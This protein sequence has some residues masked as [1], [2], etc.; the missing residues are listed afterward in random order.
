[1]KTAPMMTPKEAPVRET[2]LERY[3]EQP[4]TLQHWMDRSVSVSLSRI[5]IQTSLSLLIR[6]KL[7]D[8]YHFLINH[9]RRHLHQIDSIQK[10]Q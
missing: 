3:Q 2:V 9:N 8:L 7:G 4:N 10:G 1:M 5:R 6:L